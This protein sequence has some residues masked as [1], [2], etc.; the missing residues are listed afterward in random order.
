[1]ACTFVN[2]VDSVSVMV[3][4]LAGLPTDPP[5]LFFDIEGKQLSRTGTVSILQILV[6]P[7]NHVFLIDIHVLQESAFNTPG[8]DGTNLRT[9]FESSSIPKVCFD[10][11]NDS[12]A[13]CFHYGIAFQ[14]VL[15]LQ[16]MENASRPAYARR[17]VNGLQRCIMTDAPIRM[18]E[19]QNWIAVKEKGVKLFDPNKGGSYEVFNTRPLHADIRAYCEQDVRILP[20][21]RAVYWSRLDARWKAKVEAET[22]TRVLSSQSPHYQPHGPHK[23][24]SPW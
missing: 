16:L 15:D 4:G 8:K 6:H 14:G 23:A 9:I 22:K 13:L 11:R 17:L 21:L 10:V 7:A 18:E 24:L 5:S 3:D 12:D 20:L 1:M 2:T 19:R